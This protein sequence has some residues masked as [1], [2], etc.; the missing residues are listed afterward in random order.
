DGAYTTAILGW[1]L[2]W[3]KGDG[4]AKHS[5]GPMILVC[6]NWA[7]SGAAQIAH[8]FHL[9]FD[10]HQYNDRP[11]FPGKVSACKL[12]SGTITN[13]EFVK[14]KVDYDVTTVLL[15]LPGWK[16]TSNLKRLN[17]F[18]ERMHTDPE[19]GDA[20]KHKSNYE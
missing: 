19:I 20:L 11:P 8:G 13:N 2:H 15:S 4:D 18:V 1:K 14:D 5:S 6:F 16:Y 10:G 9:H 7:P 17:S 3:Y 12:I